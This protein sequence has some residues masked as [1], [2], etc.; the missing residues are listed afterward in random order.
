M[1]K[2][3]LCGKQTSVEEI[4]DECIAMIEDQE[5]NYEELEL[6]QEAEDDF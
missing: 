4:C 3:I 6:W 5:E 2:C 1:P